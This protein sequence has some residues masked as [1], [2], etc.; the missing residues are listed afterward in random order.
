MLLKS[1]SWI[2]RLL[3]AIPVKHSLFSIEA[4]RI[5]QDTTTWVRLVTKATKCW[6]CITVVDDT[7]NNVR[8]Q[9]LTTTTFPKVEVSAEYD[10]AYRGRP[11][12]QHWRLVGTRTDLEQFILVVQGFEPTAKISNTCGITPV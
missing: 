10:T 11:R 6:C 8:L 4:V 7:D 5:E 3:C 2:V 1:K 9:T 12:R